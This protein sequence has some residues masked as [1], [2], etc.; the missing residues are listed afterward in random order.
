MDSYLFLD[1]I[2]IL[3]SY[4]LE[5]E[6]SLIVGLERVLEG[7]EFIQHTT[8]GPYITLLVVWPLFAHLGAEVVRRPH[9]GTSEVILIREHL[10]YSQIAYAY[11]LLTAEEYIHRLDVAV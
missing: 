8:E 5:Y 9:H 4:D 10:S 3:A 7:A 2:S 1:Y 11:L 6:C